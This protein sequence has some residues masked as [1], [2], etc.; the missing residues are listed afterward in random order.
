MGE[1]TFNFWNAVADMLYVISIYLFLETFLTVKETGVCAKRFCFAV[2]WVILTALQIYPNLAWVTILADI[3][4]VFGLTHFYKSSLGKRI[5]ATGFVLGYMLILE[6]VGM[7]VVMGVLSYSLSNHALAGTSPDAPAPVSVAVI[8]LISVLLYRKIK[9]HREE[10]RVPATY[11]ITVI[12]VPISSLYITVL[13]YSFPGVK[14]WQMLSI[15][16]IMLVISVSV[17]VLYERQVRFFV[18]ENRKKVLEVQNTYYKRQLD[19]VLASENAARTLRHD[20]KNHLLAI[21]ALAEK[22]NSQEIAD[23]VNRIYDVSLL[24]ASHISTGNVVIDSILNHKWML[25]E[26]K[27]IRMT[28]DVSI[29]ATL[30]LDDMDAT[31]LLGNLLDNAIEG[32]EKSDE[33]EVAL[34]IRYDRGRLLFCCENQYAGVIKR[35][36]SLYDTVK[37]DRRNHGM[38]LKSIKGVVEKYNGTMNI[39]DENHIFKVEILLYVPV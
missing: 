37:A 15:M 38:G 29:P 24:G 25:A 9:Q 7:V 20:M 33:K 17:F 27:E 2:F 4:I 39:V 1:I 28:I 5:L 22:S 12:L 19:Y 8:A 26:E 31:V 35:R 30:G 34:S 10:V 21:S 18:E 3:V 32:A 23:Y 6:V 11:W 14:K 36:G 13:V 16:L